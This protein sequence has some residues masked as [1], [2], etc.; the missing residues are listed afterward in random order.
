[1][2]NPLIHIVD[3]DY[4]LRRLLE[5]TMKT[6]GYECRVF[7]SG[8]SFLKSLDDNPNV[9]LLDHMMPGLS[10]LETLKTIKDK[11]PELPVI[12]LSAQGKIDV[13]V[14]MMRAGATDYFT[15]PID[16]KR[17]QFALANAINLHNLQDKVRQ[18]QD[19]LESSVR[20]ENIISNSGV[21]QDVLK[22][23][24]KARNSE[25]NVLIEGESGTGKE[26]I[27]RAIHFNGNR[28]DYP[29][30]VIN[31]AAIPREL[32]ESELF[33][34]E[35]G[36][37]TGAIERKI[38]KFEAAHTGTIFLDEI[39][40]L[41]MSL[42]AKMLRVIHT[43]QFERVG[44]VDTLSSD[45]RVISATNRDLLS[46]AEQRE[47]R[48]DLYY[49]L[50]TFPI[51]LPSLRERPSE[52]TLLAEHFLSLFGEREDR[53]NITFHADTLA[54]LQRY[55]WPGNVRELQS[56]IE[57]SVLLAE[58]DVIR[59][60][61]LPQALRFAKEDGSA[62]SAALAFAS[63]EDVVPLERI[64]EKV[65]RRALE[66]FEGNISETARALDIGRTTLYDIIKKFEIST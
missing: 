21:M 19:T 55:A 20:F 8:D 25:I 43:K 31:C 14:E 46:M 27:A 6:W 54:L 32:L 15:K 57:R 24:D 26:L 60:Q 12:M 23:V 45:V 58:T 41:D 7:S 40:E 16:L 65:V 1:M 3:D 50:S 39:G 56:V 64:K 22:L 44:G 66:L 9:V 30:V 35:R 2:A 61:D 11:D 63:R 42:Q 48:E 53:A 13:A 38:G 47:F 18:L 34:H 52:I 49:R 33:G 59:P 28:K 10:G 36:A 17:L 62:G 51:K 37:F 5:F 29:F 4:S